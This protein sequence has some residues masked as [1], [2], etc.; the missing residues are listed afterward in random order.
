MDQARAVINIKEGVIEIEGPVEFVRLYLEKYAPAM[1]GKSSAEPNG[2][3]P[4]KKLATRRSPKGGRRLCTRAIRAEIK[5]GFFD[6]P[7]SPHAVKERLNE[8]GAVCS[9]GTLRNSLKKVV[10]EERLVTAGRG[11]GLVYG[12]KAEDGEVVPPA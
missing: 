6:K 12:R 4:G 1:K 3:T 11:R 5:A 7:R 10:E 2:G 9:I 8:K